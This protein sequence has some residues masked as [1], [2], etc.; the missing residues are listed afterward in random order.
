M[1]SI[2]INYNLFA[3]P[4]GSSLGLRL[5]ALTVDQITVE[6]VTIT[7][8]LNGAPPPGP[9]IVYET[10]VQLLTNKSFDANTCTF[11]NTGDNTITAAIASNGAA[12]TGSILEFTQTANR[13]YTIPDVALDCDIVLTE[14]NQTI[15]GLKS[16]ANIS[17]VSIAT[18][19][20]T[21]ATPNNGVEI[22][23]IRIAED[24]IVAPAMVLGSISNVGV[25]ADISLGLVP[26]GNGAII[27]AIPDNAATGGGMRGSYAID[28]QLLR[29]N[30]T[31]VASGANSIVVGGANNTSSN[32]YSIVLGGS[33]NTSSGVSSVVVGGTLAEATGDYSFAWG[34]QAKAANAGSF[35][36]SDSTASDFASTTADQY[37]ARFAGGYRLTGGKLSLN[38][39]TTFHSG[40]T[41]TT[42][43]VLVVDIYTIPTTPGRVYLF[44]IKGIAKETATMDFAY[45]TFHVHGANV[46]GVLTL[47]ATYLVITYDDI[48]L[49]PA[50]VYPVAIGSDLIIRVEGLVTPLEWVVEIKELFL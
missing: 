34:T 6:N 44:E 28:L 39:N 1:S 31:Q 20:I 36:I 8:T 23:S 21:E 16:F 2:E 29:A 15:N 7:G 24:T 43:P 5:F 47:G 42:G 26:K 41:G 45:Q 32:Q 12:G 10:A 38:D 25:A 37:N 13:T 17:V 22:D 11:V 46:A 35:V 30:S 3:V 33:D 9:G 14:G 4:N 40:I 19:T 18:D 49:S 50:F 48:G 27:G